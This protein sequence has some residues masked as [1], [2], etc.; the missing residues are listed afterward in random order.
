MMTSDEQVDYISEDVILKIITTP[1]LSEE[2]WKRVEVELKGHEKEQLHRILNNAKPE[3]RT[4]DEN[5]A[6]NKNLDKITDYTK[7]LLKSSPLSSDLH[8]QETSLLKR[9][10]DVDSD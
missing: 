9:K 3:D 5:W 10:R 2:L 8:D 7:F 4:V 6:I 1:E